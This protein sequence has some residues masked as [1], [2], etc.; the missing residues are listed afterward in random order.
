MKTY[1]SVSDNYTLKEGSKMKKDILVMVITII[2]ACCFSPI[3]SNADTKI[4]V[5]LL[6]GTKQYAIESGVWFTEIDSSNW[7]T[8]ILLGVGGIHFPNYGYSSGLSFAI[9]ADAPGIKFSMK[10]TYANIHSNYMLSPTVEIRGILASGNSE[11]WYDC[12]YC[13]DIKSNYKTAD[14]Y[15]G[16]T[17]RKL[18]NQ[19]YDEKYKVYCTF[20]F[21]LTKSH[22]HMSK[23]AYDPYHLGPEYN[24]GFDSHQSMWIIHFGV[25][26]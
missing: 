21:N 8:R 26:F 5:S 18:D 17:L 12:L 25:L 10:E 2:I 14:I 23:S 22:T 16:I 11:N 15:Y 6:F 1:N 4:P 9:G 13:S 19:N 24:R 3:T 20:L 7:S